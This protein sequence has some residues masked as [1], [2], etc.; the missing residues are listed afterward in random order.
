MQRLSDEQLVEKVTAAVQE[1]DAELRAQ[2][3]A[4][5]NLRHPHVGAVLF[6]TTLVGGVTVRLSNNWLS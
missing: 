6:V 2:M 5:G 1:R 4:V 3:R